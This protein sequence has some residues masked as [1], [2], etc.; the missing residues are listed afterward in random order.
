MT[1]GQ[2]C[3]TAAPGPYLSPDRLNDARAVVLKGV[4]DRTGSGPELQADFQVWDVADG[5][6]RQQ[7]LRRVGDQSNEVYVQL[8][9]DS[10]QLDGVTYGWRVRVLDGEEAGPWSVTC[11]FTVDRSGG[12]APVVTSAEYPAGSWDNASGAI[13]VPGRFK[14]AAAADD[15]VSYEYR[16]YSSEVGGDDAYSMVDADRLG[17]TATIGWTPRAASYHSLTVYAVDRAGNRSQASAHEFV[18][19]ET[20]PWIFSAAY[21]DY[22]ANLNYNVGV[23]GE[24]ELGST[25]PDT[26]SFSWRIDDGP[27]GTVPANAD[28]KATVMIAPTRAGRQTLHVH[29]VTR[30]GTVHATRS[31]EF[32]VDNGPRITGDT[33]R[34]VVIGSSLSFHLAPRTP[35]VEAYVYWPEHSGLEPRPA[36]KVTIPARPDG[37]A[38]LTWTATETSVVALRFQSRSANGTL[39]EPRRTSVSVDGA[40]P[41]V[42][43]TG[44]AELGTSATLTARTRMANVAEYV[45]TLNGDPTTRKV[46]KPATDGTATFQFTPTKGGY[47]YVSVVARNAAGVQTDA[48]GTSWTV[49]DAPHVTSTDFPT[50]GSGRLAPGTFTFTPRLPGTTGYEYSINY[51]PYLAINATAAGSATLNWTPTEAGPQRLAVRSVTGAGTRSSITVYAFT[52]EA[53]TVTTVTAVTPATVQAGGVR[54]ITISGTGLHLRDAVQLTPAT[55]PALTATVK[56]VSADGTAMTAEVNLTSAA[57]GPASLTLR[58]YGAN[59]ALVRAAAVTIA[60]PPPLRSV[61]KPTI[62]GTVA[63]GSTVKANPGEWTPAAT[64]Y[65]YQWLANGTAIKG[66]NAASYKI[67]ASL[68]GKRLTVTVTASRSGHTATKATSAATTTVAKG[69]APKAT[70][71]PKIV[72]TAK[73]GRTVKADVGTWSPKAD[74]YRYEWRLNGKLI[75]GATGRTLKL[76]SSMRNKKI[77]VTVIAKKAGYADGRSTSTAVTV[78]R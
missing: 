3:V 5:E 25:V 21:P 31:Y 47:T 65:T 11:Y 61:R 36:E 52:V 70:K 33:D 56:T 48:G 62:S 55:G 14:L 51:G 54:T 50:S 63:V 41:T 12:P 19:R 67:P 45:A 57:T 59:G 75:K 37:T 2:S 29:S 4:F 69:K 46:V 7:W 58:P 20:R 13:G 8:E 24:F 77:T 15:T 78:R 66:A 6:N 28:G 72:G 60:P 34:G 10:R 27:S 23:A 35:D 32:L 49:N 53:T 71:K 18:V 64:A 16:F 17:G 39:S 76:K 42:T 73:V 30:D 26:A 22:G 68:L 1:A 9:D 74:S 40:A 43:R 38:D 44:G